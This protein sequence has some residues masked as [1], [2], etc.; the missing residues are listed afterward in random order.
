MHDSVE[1][2]AIQI[3]ERWDGDPP[4]VPAL[5]RRWLAPEGLLYVASWVTEDFGSVS[6]SCSARS[7]TPMIDGPPAGPDRF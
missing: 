6:K 2:D 7:V 3:V 1:P 5:S 4:P